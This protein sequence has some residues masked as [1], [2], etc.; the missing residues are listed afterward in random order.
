M[1]YCANVESTSAFMIVLLYVLLQ[2]PAG[3]QCYIAAQGPMET[4]VNDFW[5]MIL[6]FKV[7]VIICDALHDQLPFAQL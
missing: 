7:K 5:R 6:Q 1:I 3:S 2:D 4:T